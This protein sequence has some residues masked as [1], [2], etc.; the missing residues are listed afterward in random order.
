[1]LNRIFKILGVT[2]L[3]IGTVFIVTGSVVYGVLTV[4]RNNIINDSFPTTAIVASTYR[5]AGGTTRDQIWVRYEVD[6]I[7]YDSQLSFWSSSMFVGQ[8]LDIYVRNDNHERFITD[9]SFKWI[10]L[11]VGLPIGIVFAAIGAGFM[12]HISK[13]RKNHRWLLDY[14]HPII[15][16]VEG[17]D[18]NFAVRINGRPTTVVVATFENM[19]FVSN[20]LSNNELK[21]I[22]D[23]VK[24]F[25][26]PENSDNYTF[27]F[28]NE[29]T[30][31]MY[32]F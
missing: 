26:D 3:I 32:N 17:F 27:D 4:R 7:E 5:W 11:V 15:A 29:S 20:P 10:S 21:L 6:G 8:E 18:K 23:K 24:V 28:K 12:Y 16:T 19:E 22:G 1:M 30:Q 2:F 14:G 25:V 13:Q 9:I 31:M